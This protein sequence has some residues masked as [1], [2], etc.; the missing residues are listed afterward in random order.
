MVAPGGEQLPG[1]VR[2]SFVADATDDEPGGDVQGLLL[3]G[4]GGVARLGDLGVGGPAAELVVPD[5]LLVLD[6]CHAFSGMA[7]MAARMPALAGAVTANWAPLP[8]AAARLPA[9]RT[10]GAFP[11]RSLVA[12][13]TGAASG[14]LTAVRGD[15]GQ[16]RYRVVNCRE[17]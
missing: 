9:P 17:R 13:A 16:S 8:R 5:G 11:P 4:E 7:A 1:P 3:G 15:D 14:V 10:E 6:A 12:A 2:P